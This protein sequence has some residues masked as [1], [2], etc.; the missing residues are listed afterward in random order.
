MTTSEIKLYLIKKII[1][2]TDIDLLLKIK[3]LLEE[4]N[5]VL[6]DENPTEVNEPALK[7]EKNIRIFSPAEQRK[8]DQALREYENGE[9]ISDEEAQ[10]EIQAWLED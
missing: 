2:T 9:C 4:N 8:I 1:E 6:S 3:S 5:Y 7:Y 10:K